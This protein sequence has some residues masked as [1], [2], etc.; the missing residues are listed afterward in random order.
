MAGWMK[1]EAGEKEMPPPV[2]GGSQIEDEQRKMPTHA[3][4]CQAVKI[5]HICLRKNSRRVGTC[6]RRWRGWSAQRWAAEQKQSRNR[7]A[8]KEEEKGDFP[9]DLFVI[10]ENCRDLLVK[11]NLTTVLELK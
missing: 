11:K 10:L 7:A 5:R 2:A 4:S 1:L 8:P 6:S 3:C 9:R